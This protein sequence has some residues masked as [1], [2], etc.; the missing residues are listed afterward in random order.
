MNDHS[1]SIIETE[2]FEGHGISAAEAGRQLDILLNPPGYTSLDRPCVPGDGIRILTDD[3]KREALDAFDEAVKKNRLQKM[4]PASGAASR[5]FQSLFHFLNSRTRFTR[6]KCEVDAAGGDGPAADLLRFMDGVTRFAFHE[7]L[8]GAIERKGGNLSK[9]A[10]EFDYRAILGALL[11]EDG[12]HFASSP[13]GLIPFHRYA[14]NARTPF[15]EHLVEGALY[16]R[17]GEGVSP[18]HFTVSPEHR[19]GFEGLLQ[20]SR[21][22][23]EKRFDVR[24][25]ITF[26][27]QKSSTD[28]IA[29]D[30]DNR[31]FR[32]DDGAPLFRP[33][34]HGALIENLNDLKGD[35]ILIKNIDNVSP[36]QLTDRLVVWK[37]YLAGHLAKI[38]EE[39][40]LHV[41]RLE[42]ENC[43]EEELKA[44][45]RF[46]V[47][48][49][50]L[51]VHGEGDGSL[52]S[53]LLL[54]RLRRPIRVCGMVIN[55]GAPGGGPFWVRMNDGTT[56]PQIVESAQVDPGEAG[57]IAKLKSSTHF[58]PVD[59]VCGVR[60]HRDEP[61]DLSRF[62]DENAVFLSNKSR[63]GRQLKAL[64][65]PGL[66]NGAM[67]FWN[68]IF[69]EVPAETFSPVKTVVD[70]L[71]D[72]HQ[73]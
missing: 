15:E 24:F 38:Q 11:S 71:D 52:R 12:L 50:N 70:L 63:G 19:A 18:I 6:E 37:K 64:E 61:Y 28:T 10:A 73:V 60:N 57:Q 49:L 53:D 7:A 65:R 14:E 1:F 48:E 40:F 44:A 43:G 56:T 23:I 29:I 59:L 32:D 41:A 3:E 34:G 17:N 58:N 68:T 51:G 20:R 67:A 9:A 39:L 31:L 54:E 35:I 36:G 26:S 8:A 42:K 47:R 22:E 5:M 33:G 46:A 69:V 27:E 21:P 66:W 25:G 55:E 45:G 30:R 16:A 13:K 4:V 72:V 2:A 62:I